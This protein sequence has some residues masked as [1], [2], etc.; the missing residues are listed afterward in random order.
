[1]SRLLDAALQYHEDG[2][3]VIPCRPG[4][5]I[6]MVRWGPSAKRPTVAM[7]KGFWD[8]EREEDAPSIALKLDSKTLVLDLDPRHEPRVKGVYPKLRSET[9]CATTPSGGLHAWY[10]LAKGIRPRTFKGLDV[11]TKGRMALVPPSEG[12]TWASRDEI[13][14]LSSEEAEAL[15]KDVTQKAGIRALSE[16]EG[17][18]KESLA[19]LE[20]IPVHARNHTLTAIAGVL[21]SAGFRGDRLIGALD[22]LRQHVTEQPPDD[23]ITLQ[24]ITRICES[25][26]WRTPQPFEYAQSVYY[27]FN[28]TSVPPPLKWMVSS[29]FP[30]EGVTSLFGLGKQGKSYVAMELYRCLTLRQDFL[31]MKVPSKPVRV[32]YVDWER[33]GESLQRRMHTLARGDA[34]D[35]AV[36]QPGGSLPNEIEAIRARVTLGGFAAVVIDS[37]TIA[38]MQGDVKEAFVVVP[39]LFALNSFGV[40]VFALDHMKKPQAGEPYES[41]TAFGSVFKQNV[42]SMN[43]RLKKASG[44]PLGMNIVMQNAGNNFEVDPPDIHARISFDFDSEG[45]VARAG[46]ERMVIQAVE[47]DVWTYLAN[48]VDAVPDEDIARD[49]NI[50]IGQVRKALN[51]LEA[52]HRVRIMDGM[53]EACEATEDNEGDTG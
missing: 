23:P 22:G 50:P 2:G 7:L 48:Q 17:L 51:A 10:K 21:R 13:K 9:R 32:L 37:L 11:L 33:R 49:M 20:P 12:R 31:E 6:P 27:E 46:V 38:L 4:T 53:W 30:A 1:M 44:D 19:S 47:S 16:G 34:F 39:A 14:E 5:K 36:Y 40:P 3:F 43:W 28:T 24:D 25:I 52:V 8:V 29:F 45:Q 41:L 15:V 35:V 18:A 42:C 26:D